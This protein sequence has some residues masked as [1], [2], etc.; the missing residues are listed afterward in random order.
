MSGAI[1]GT[2][3][4]A[5]SQIEV[6]GMSGMQPEDLEKGAR[7]MWGGEPV[8]VDGPQEL[9]LLGDA[10][11]QADMRTRAARTVKKLVGAITENKPVDQVSS[12]NA[13]GDVAVMMTDG[14][15]TFTMTI[16]DVPN[17]APL[18]MFVDE[19]PP[20]DVDLWVVDRSGSLT[21]PAVDE[22][23]KPGGII[24]FTDTTFIGTPDGFKRVSDLRPGDMVQTRDNGAK[25]I[26]WVGQRRISGARLHVMPQMR[27]IRIKNNAFGAQSPG[28]DLLVS[29]Q[30]RMVVK[31]Q[32]ALDLFNTDEVLVAAKDL[33][34][35]RS[36]YH[37][38]RIREVNYYHIL[39]EQHEILWANGILSESFHPANMNLTTL[40]EDQRMAMYELYPDLE[41]NPES[42]GGDARRSLSTP[43]VEILKSFG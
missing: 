12:D 13:M 8:R 10:D 36:I 15:D 40:A 42:Y 25:P 27:P 33:V 22:A 35:G 41:W 34:N 4:I 39:M 2:Y 7:W 1:Q 3:V 31:G 5:W 9:L 32:V 20:R 43:E 16:I 6:D 19:L 30:H 29:P 18:A 26:L 23:P 37:E 24:C 17:S 21:A 38:S 14:R 28:G 11:G